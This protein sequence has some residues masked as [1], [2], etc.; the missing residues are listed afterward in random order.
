MIFSLSKFQHTAARRRLVFQPAGAVKKGTVSTHSRLKAAGP[1]GLGLRGGCRVSTHSRP[2]AAGA[3]FLFLKPLIRFQ[4]TA[5]RRRLATP[6]RAWT[7]WYACF[8]TQPPE[9][10]WVS[11]RLGISRLAVSTQNAANPVL[12]ILNVGFSFRNYAFLVVF[13]CNKIKDRKIFAEQIIIIR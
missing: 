10:G 2:K 11:S 12:P 1:C 7:C 13:L 6:N 5:A 8:N 3:G 9:G 4:H